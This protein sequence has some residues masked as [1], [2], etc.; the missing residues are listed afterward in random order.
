MSISTEKPRQGGPL[1]WGRKI[2]VR[3]LPSLRYLFTTEVHAY[4]FSIAANIYL[5]FFP[6]ALLLLSVCRRWLHWEG[7]YEIIL[8]LLRVHLPA[9]TDSVVK[10]LIALVQGRPRLQAMSVFMLFF[11]ASGV[12]LPLEVSLNKVWGI[13]RNRSFLRN[14]AVSFAL[15]VVA[16]VLAL[17]WISVATIAQA[18]LTFLF[19]WI[20]SPVFL[21]IVSRGLLETISIPFAVSIFFVIYYCLPN[22]QVPVERVL[23]AA[24]ISGLLMTVARFVYVLTL[25]FFRFREVYGPFALSVTL[26]FW[27]FVGA[28]IMLFGAHLSVQDF[29]DGFWKR[30]AV[31]AGVKGPGHAAGITPT[32]AF[33]Y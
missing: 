30:R 31:R 32:N 33:R 17:F 14:L 9:G 28:L 21:R 26:L 15:A 5:S 24:V 23:P 1:Q 2:V 16:G 22:G 10:N 4:A 7:A 25:P 27:A 20:P 18:M 3:M 8:G 29:W 13:A 19:D 11:T 12:F 6:F